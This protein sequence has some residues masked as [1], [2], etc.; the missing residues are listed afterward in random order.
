MNHQPAAAHGRAATQPQRAAWLLS[1]PAPAAERPLPLSQAPQG[2]PPSLPRSL[3]EQAMQLQRAAGPPVNLA[4]FSIQRT[5]SGKQLKGAN[6]A[7][8]RMQKVSHAV[9]AVPATLDSSG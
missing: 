2:M 8:E 4:P 7:A 1:A 3:A 6:A 5:M 9:R